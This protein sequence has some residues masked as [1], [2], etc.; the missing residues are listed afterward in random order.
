MSELA[1]P[2]AQFQTAAIAPTL[3][4]ERVPEPD[5]ANHPAYGRLF[6]KATFGSTVRAVGHLLPW[7]GL[8]LFKRILLFDRLPAPP[9]YDGPFA[10]GIGRRIAGIPRYVGC[11]VRGHTANLRHLLIGG[12]AH[13][14]ESSR[15]HAL[16]RDGAVGV[17]FAPGEMDAIR[18]EV[19]GTLAELY[20]RRDASAARTF[21][22]NQSWLNRTQLP[23]VYALLE[24]VLTANAVFTD[25]SAYLG[26]PVSISYVTLQ[27]NDTRDAFHH[28]KFADVGLPD[29]AT[30]YMHVDTTDEILKF[31][32]Y[33]DKVTEKNGPF[34]YVKGTATSKLGWFEGI[35]RR[36]V[37]RSGLSGYSVP[38]RRMFMA[39][40]KPL[41][42]KCT[43]GS[44]LLDGTDGTDALIAAEHRFTSADGDAILFDNLGVHRGALVEVGERQILVV[45]LA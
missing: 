45:T 25:A 35:V 2:R 21:E 44:D 28:D 37:D 22:G 8:V 27:L 9:D 16:R 4:I 11:M 36:A 13:T 43:F 38:T 10:A 33:L 40:P 14:A 15:L 3:R 29:P 32:I 34:C 23:G 12:G 17:L 19:A 30:N 24:R 18:G 6:G 39:L 31:M 5:Y 41:R 1:S 20:K 7:I 42:R 26:R